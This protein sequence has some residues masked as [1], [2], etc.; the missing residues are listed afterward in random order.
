MG[1]SSEVSQDAEISASLS[2]EQPGAATPAATRTKMSAQN[3]RHNWGGVRSKSF[4]ASVSGSRQRWQN[5]P[6][7]PATQYH[8]APRT[9]QS[10]APS[11]DP[12][13]T[14]PVLQ[15]TDPPGGDAQIIG[16]P[17]DRH[18]PRSPIRHRSPI[19]PVRRSIAPR[20]RPR[21]APCQTLRYHG[22]LDSRTTPRNFPHCRR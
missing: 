7:I 5:Q 9:P 19:R 2:Y 15:A 13:L 6:L 1:Q 21:K 18:P 11:R 14:T 22:R 20:I 17:D 10:L 8:I 3:H 16:E 4:T 12:P